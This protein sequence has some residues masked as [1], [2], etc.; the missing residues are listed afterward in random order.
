M[1]GTDHQMPQPWLG[2][3]VAEANAIQDDYEF[4]VTSLPEY[5]ADPAGRRTS[6]RWT[7]SCARARAPTCSWVS[8]RT[9]STCTARA[10][11][12][13]ARSRSGPS[14]CRRCSC[15][16]ASTRTRSLE[17]VW[18]KLVL[19]SAHDSSC[20]CSHDEVVD[21]VVV[22]Y[23]EARQIGDGLARDA[24]HAL[25]ARG[26][27]AR[28]AR[29]RR[30]PD[31]ARRG[32]ASS[33]RACPA[34]GPCALRRPRRASRARRSCSPSTAATRR[35]SSVTGQKVRW[36]LDLMRGTEFA[37]R[38]ITSYDVTERRRPVTRSCCAKPAPA[39]SALRPRRAEGRRCSRSASA[40]T[41]CGCASCSRA[42]AARAVRHRRRSTASAGRASPRATA[43]ASGPARGDGDR[44]L[45]NEHL[46][47]RRST[48][49]TARTRSTTADGLRVAGLGRLVDGGDGGDTYNYSPPDDRPRHRPARS[50][51]RVDDA[52]GRPGARP[53]A[54]RRR[55]HAG[56]RTP[57]ATSAPASQ[58]SDE[59]VA[60][61]VRTTLELRAG[62]AVPARRARDRQPRARPPAA[63]ALPAARAGRPAPTPSARSRSCTAGSR[64]KAA[65]HEFGLPTFPSRRF[66]DASDGDVGL[67]LVHDGLLEYE[68]V[69]DGTR[70][71]AHAAARGRA[72]SRAPNRRCGRTRPGPPIR[73]TARSST[74]AQR[75]EY[76]VLL[77]RGDWR[78]ADCYGAAD[79]FLV[80]FERARVRRAR[81][82]R[83]GR[84]GGHAL[85]VDGAEVSAVH[86]RAGRARRARVPH[87]ARRGPGH[88]RARRRAR[89]RLCRRPPRP[90]R[91]A[92]SKARSRSARGRSP[93]CSLERV[94]L[95]RS[96]TGYGRRSW[97]ASTGSTKPARLYLP[98]GQERVAA[99][100][101][102]EPVVQLAR[103]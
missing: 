40:A 80:P 38:Q 94:S 92:R 99:A 13:S 82:P 18:R 15:R 45:A 78:A 83:P 62:R 50:R 84:R 70:A 2:R 69:D 31:G 3:V 53:R 7:A 97:Y 63:R 68:V 67:A 101:A 60:C 19:N 20:A 74:G 1:N 96:T 98:G 73:S 87:R 37:G 30:E 8:A 76:A 4:V 11:R 25:A 23:A 54:D 36:V 66:V 81:R 21:Q 59:T 88:D 102:C 10:R 24:L 12:P 64:P 77:H 93:P 43:T 57:T 72:T 55:L 79:A 44:A 48:P 41:R 71:R 16:R 39:T 47:G 89:P 28:R 22:R 29:R 6:S 34:A 58:R 42:G 26:R 61:R 86:A 90:P 17:L 103:R 91:R 27:R 14:R 56:P 75:A 9:A 46:R 49:P 52:R 32:P 35:R 65:S 85:R 95:T 33:K 5:L 100:H 51:S